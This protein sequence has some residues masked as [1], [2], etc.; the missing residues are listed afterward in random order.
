[1]RFGCPLATAPARLTQPT[2]P[3]LEASMI[4]PAY[5]LIRCGGFSGGSR[6]ASIQNALE[7]RFVE[8]TFRLSDDNCRNTVADEIC[9][10][11]GL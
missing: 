8:R 10:R 11:A 9:E 7:L 3:V 2:F 5:V 4:M 1:M 6:L